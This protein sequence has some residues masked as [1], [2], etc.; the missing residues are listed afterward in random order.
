VIPRS[1]RERRAFVDSSA[2]LALLDSD[3][4]HHREAATILSRLID[5]RYRLYTTNSVV[6]EAHAL[7]LSTLGIARA[8]SFLRDIE[9]SRMVVVRTRASDERLAQEVIFRYD[10]KRFSFTDAISFVVME[11]LGIAYAFSFDRNFAQY[12]LQLLK[13]DGPEP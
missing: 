9:N 12:G 6:I 4:D 1:S 3:D 11:R 2:Y 13:A 7:I 5:G 8:S 10:D